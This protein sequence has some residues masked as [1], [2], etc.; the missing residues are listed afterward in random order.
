MGRSAS[1]RML[2]TGVAAVDAG[3]GVLL[4]GA[5]PAVADTINVPGDFATIQ[6]AEDNANTG[7]V[8]RIKP[9][10]YDE[11]VEVDVN[12]L[13]FVG[14]NNKIVVDA[15]GTGDE[16]FDIDAENVT[17]QNLRLRNG[18]S[19][20]VECDQATEACKLI[21][22]HVEGDTSDDC[23][24][25]DG[26][27]NALVRSSSFEGCDEDGVDISADDVRVE[28]STFRLEQNDCARGRR[29]RRRCRTQLH[30]QLR[31]GRPR[32]RRRNQRRR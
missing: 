30:A 2:R 14:T 10:K 27:S 26:G 12:D 15:D 22:V 11:S 9:G 13:T 20:G 28:R 25:V 19:D 1:R 32:D 3:P 8:I 16:V 4:F 7:D 17:L 29:R 5:Q 31:R 24:E 23:L 6:E 21:N 18:E